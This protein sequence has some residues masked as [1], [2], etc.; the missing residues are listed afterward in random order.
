[1]GQCADRFKP[2]CAF[3]QQFDRTVR[4]INSVKALGYAVI[5]MNVNYTYRSWTFGVSV[6]NLLNTDWNDAQFAGD[7][8]ITPDSDPGYGL[9]FTPG[10]PFFAKCGITFRF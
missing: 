3:K 9:T 7:Y 8:R 1:M 2:Q 10:N 5:D 6:Q 4:R